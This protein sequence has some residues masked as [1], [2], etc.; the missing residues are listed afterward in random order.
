MIMTEI[1]KLLNAYK[2]LQKLNITLDELS[3]NVHFKQN[4]K[5]QSNMLQRSIDNCLN[6]LYKSMSPSEIEAFN[7]LTI[8]DEII[9]TACN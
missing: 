2:E 1:D 6:Q 9:Q 4:I 5:R 8:Q 7:T 3:D